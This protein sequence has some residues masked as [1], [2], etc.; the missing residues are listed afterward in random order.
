MCLRSS[1]VRKSHSRA[2]VISSKAI[3]IRPE[4]TKFSGLDGSPA[5]ITLLDERTGYAKA[6]LDGTLLTAFRTAAGS[7]L[8]TQM[9]SN[10]ASKGLMVFGAGAQ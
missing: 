5:I 9:L 6:V 1:L 4:N 8:A 7:G 2:T 3:C 10:E